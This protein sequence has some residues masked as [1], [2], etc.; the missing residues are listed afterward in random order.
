MEIKGIGPVKASQ[1]LCIGELSRRIWRQAA[2][3]RLTFHDPETI[4]GYYMEEMRHKEQEELH[5]MF[6]NNRQ[7]MIQE[8]LVS[9]GTVNA[10]LATPR[11]ILIEALRYRA[12][13][14]V[15][16][17]NHPSGYPFPA[18]KTWHLQ[19]GSAW[20]E[21]WWGSDFWITLL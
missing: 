17:H 19:K 12:V 21:R 3:K 11:E 18:G 8:V 14:M 6:F 13:N 15:L 5:V 10:S 4:A 9:R 7:A 20:Q 1:L 2:G 16:V